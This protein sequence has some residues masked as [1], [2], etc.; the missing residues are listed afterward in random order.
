MYLTR[1]NIT[2]ELLIIQVIHLPTYTQILC[3][4]SPSEGSEMTFTSC[5]PAAVTLL[6]QQYYI[7]LVLLTTFPLPFHHF[8]TCLVAFAS[9]PAI[10]PRA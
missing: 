8:L 4:S 9:R 5:W 3:S 1:N 6:L 2:P 10:L 7:H